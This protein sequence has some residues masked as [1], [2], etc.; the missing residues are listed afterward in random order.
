M[1]DKGSLGSAKKFVFTKKRNNPEE[2]RGVSQ[3]RI[4]SFMVKKNV[5]ESPM[6]EELPSGATPDFCLLDE[7]E[8]DFYDQV[9]SKGG[10]KD[11]DV[12]P[13]TPSPCGSRKVYEPRLSPPP[14]ELLHS[15][16]DED[17]QEGKRNP[18]IDDEE[19]EELHVKN[20]PQPKSPILSSKKQLHSSDDDPIT[21]KPNTSSNIYKK[22]NVIREDSEDECKSSQDDE[23]PDF[24]FSF[25]SKLSRSTKPTTQPSKFQFNLNLKKM[26]NK[27]ISPLKI[28]QTPKKDP[29]KHSLIEDDEFI[30]ESPNKGPAPSK[31]RGRT[32]S[33]SSSGGLKKDRQTLTLKDTYLKIRGKRVVHKDHSRMAEF[34][35]QEL[36]SHYTS[37]LKTLVNF[38]RGKYIPSNLVD[39]ENL[40]HLWELTDK[41]SVK[42]S[43]LSDQIAKQSQK[44]DNSSPILSHL[45][46][47]D[48]QPSGSVPKASSQE[49]F[50]FQKPRNENSKSWNVQTPPKNPIQ[51]EEDDLNNYSQRKSNTSLSFSER[52]NDKPWNTQ[53]KKNPIQ[54]EDDEL[55]HHFEHHDTMQVIEDFETQNEVIRFQDPMSKSLDEGSCINYT[56]ALYEKPSRINIEGRF[57]G[58]AR[59][60]GNDKELLRK[61]FSFSS[62]L[63]KKLKSKFGIRDFR[64]NQLPA[65]NA[66]LLN[67][68][69]FVLMPTGG[70]KSL[71]YQLPASIQGGVTVVISPLVSLIYDQVSKLNGLGIPADHLSGDDYGRQR[72]IYDKLRLLTPGLTLLYVTPEKISASNELNG[73]FS[74]LYSR[75]LLNRFVID[76]AHCVS[77]WGHDFRP[78]YKLLHKLRSV[79]PEVPFMALT[80]TATPRVRTDILHQLNMKSPKWFLSSFNRQNLIYEVKPKKGKSITKDIVSMIQKDWM[81]QSGI[82]YCLSR[83]ECDKTAEDLT[84]SGIKAL[85]YHAGLKDSERSRVQDQWI[86]DKVKVVCATIAF[87]MGID[88]PDVRYVMHYSLPKSIE[89]YYQESG[90][91]GRD[92]RPSNCILFYSYGDMHRL[93]KLIEMDSNA[94]YQAQKTHHENLH[95][96]VSYCENTT[97]CRRAMQLQYFGEVFDARICKNNEK[98]TCDN[99]RSSD[100]VKSDVTTFAKSIIEM[101]IRLS[102]RSRFDQKNFTLNHMVDILRGM[103]NKKVLNSQWDTDPAY[104][105]AK[106]M[107]LSDCNRIVRKLVLEGYLWEDLVVSKEGVAMAYVK[108]GPNSNKIINGQNKIYIDMAPSRAS[109]ASLSSSLEKTPPEE[110]SDEC[111]KKLEE[112]CFDALRD[113]IAIEHPEL[114]NCYA[115]LPVDCYREIAS[116]LPVNKEDMLDVV[117]MTEVR[118]ASYGESLIPICVEFL[119]KRMNYLEDLQTAEMLRKEEED[120]SGSPYF[121]SSNVDSKGW[122]SKSKGKGKYFRGRGGSRKSYRGKRKSGNTSRTGSSLKRTGGSPTKKRG[123][124]GSGSTSG[125]RL[126]ALPKPRPGLGGGTFSLN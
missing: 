71:C 107:G 89:G 123:R 92:G 8:D 60:D 105:T 77:Q 48:P 114:N 88:K 49:K 124:G 53:S 11:D 69:T 40:D 117:H 7:D 21:F 3:K 1:S 73:V 120:N 118:Y 24:S 14:Q 68:D 64:P 31:R 67:H 51:Y 16:I 10:T 100:R 102:G 113:F 42:L 25:S 2:S 80:A 87:G 5:V 74:S 66:A 61:D 32:L 104:N 52:R 12:I 91:A 65:V 75:K 79:Y 63:F 109:V 56:D 126:M 57:L 23:H 70:G 116:K 97:D 58:D 112:D 125:L 106:Q 30:D 38:Y 50:V 4:T 6:E 54:Y 46:Q 33:H 34:E 36:Q 29:P 85:S 122:M 44:N 18:F 9:F 39:K 45:S 27:S 94:N 86:K 121:P 99:C 98:T 103:K 93:R 78:D 15:L 59:N 19:E 47:V 95:A 41:I 81:R 82:I 43:S 55:D 72:K 83:K 26:N 111:L 96:M 115:A 20:K 35:T 110:E 13:L 17:E 108:I 28:S 90:R 119:D 101:V 62:E 37:C 84:A 22:G 76:E